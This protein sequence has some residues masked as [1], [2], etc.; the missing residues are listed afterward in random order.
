MTEYRCAA[1]S[2]PMF[3]ALARSGSADFFCCYHH[4]AE[5]RDWPRITQVLIDWDCVAVE[6][7]RARCAMLQVTT[8]PK[9]LD[10]AWARL[11]QLIQG[12]W[13]KDLEPRGESYRDWGRRLEKFLLARVKG[14]APLPREPD[15]E[16]EWGTA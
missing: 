9:A 16:S 8:P 14:D 5:A 13:T 3:G 1:N 10:E 4:G 6:A 7:N 12:G 15:L 2:C 11:R